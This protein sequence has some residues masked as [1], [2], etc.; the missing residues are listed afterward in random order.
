MDPPA[1]RVALYG[2]VVVVNGIKPMERER[3]SA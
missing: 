2:V 3:L 1:A